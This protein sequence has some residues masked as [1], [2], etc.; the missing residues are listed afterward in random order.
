MASTVVVRLARRR[1]T[2]R[3]A[4]RRASPRCAT[5]VFHGVIIKIERPK[6]PWTMIRALPQAGVPIAWAVRPVA[7]ELTNNTSNARLVRRPLKRPRT[8]RGMVIA[9]DITPVITKVIA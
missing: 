4:L 8:V 6:T 2:A 1:D 9:C 7:K 3:L 5:R